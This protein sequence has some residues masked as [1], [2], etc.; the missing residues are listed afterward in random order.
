MNRKLLTTPVAAI[1]PLTVK[2]EQ[3]LFTYKKTLALISSRMG[4][5]ATTFLA[6]PRLS[7]D[8]KDIEWYTSQF[9][10]TPVPLSMLSGEQRDIYMQK[11]S[12][13]MSA[14]R[15]ALPSADD[16][17]Y[18]LMT[19]LAI[20][21]NE[22][23]IYCGEG[24]VV[25]TQWGII[26]KQTGNTETLNLLK[27]GLAPKMAKPAVTP[28]APQEPAA[29]KEIK[30]NPQPE[31]PKVETP[32]STKEENTIPETKTCSNPLPPQPPLPPYKRKEKRKW[33]KW[34]WI[35]LALL[36]LLIGLGLL[37][38]SCDNANAET[39]KE[40]KPVAPPVK[41]EEMIVSEDSLNYIASD[42]LNVY[43]LKGGTLDDFSKAFRKEW[44]DRQKYQMFNPDTTLKRIVLKVPA[45]ELTIMKKEIPNRLKD[46]EIVVTEENIYQRHAAL[47]D[48]ALSRQD[49]SYYLDM[50]NAYE[51]WDIEQGSDDV[52]VAVLDGDIDVTHPEIKD[53]IVSPYDAVTH[54][55]NVPHV[56]ACEG[57]GTHTS[58]TAVGLAD[59]GQGSAGI[60]HGCK[61]MPINVFTDEGY[62]YDSLQVDGIMYAISNGADI[63]SMSIGQMFSPMTKFIP[64]ETQEQIA[65]TTNKEEEEMWEKIYSY[66][67]EK[68]V[69]I[70]KSAGNENILT[71]LD[72]QNRSERV[73]IVSAVGPDGQQ[74]IFNPLT[75]DASNYGNAC[76]ISA[77][78]SDIFQAVPGGF[79]MMS[80]TSMSCPMVAG[81]AAL[82][83]SHNP[84]LTPRQIRNV[85]IATANPKPHANIG[86]I[87]DLAAALKADPDNLPSTPPDNSGRIPEPA[88]PANPFTPVIGYNPT[89]APGTQP[90]PSPSNP[91]IPHPNPANPGGQ[92]H[93]ELIQYQYQTLE[94]V[95]LQLEKEMQQLRS[96]CPECFN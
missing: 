68:G 32:A 10:S 54:T 36:L 73:L 52:I 57:H 60:A 25:I 8:G 27:F 2:G 39:V 80:G 50:V 23:C 7:P 42:R 70:V 14:Y 95:R 20:V 22:D 71:T 56:K 82:L 72:P 19:K 12:Q 66:A 76:R 21:A 64:P 92:N 91:G 11:L 75:L 33:L 67:E 37:L 62:S 6:E 35:I 86:P 47:N 96:Q 49:L 94:Q 45:D 69:T 9:N 84:N 48:P 65:A 24:K 43:V 74:S 55:A 28:P 87:M 38:R 78:G 90:A 51:A 26:P 89:P 81:G 34:L 44:G 83:K 85:L 53:K 13:I 17:A 77:P 1:T 41:S 59:N 5:T 4:G 16:D 18:P 93:C 15:N 58:S 63:I 30:P 61:L 31:N 88:N 40:M 79:G 3:P 29:Q 46:F